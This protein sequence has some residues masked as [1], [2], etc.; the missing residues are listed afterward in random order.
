MW[1]DTHC[2]LDF[3]YENKS[4]DESLFDN[5][6]LDYIICPSAN[7]KSFGIL[8][9]LNQ[10]NKSIV[11]AFGYHPLY[12][13]DLPDNPIQYLENE[14][15]N[16]QPIAVGEI[17]L[18][19]YLRNEEKEKQKII[20]QQQLELASKYKLPVILHVRSAID[21]VLKI[22][23]DFPDIKGI[24]HAFNGSFQQAQQ[25]I[26]MGFK[27]G[28]GGA[29]T[30][31]RAKKINRLALELR[32][33][34]IVLETDAPDMK[35]AWVNATS[36]NHPNEIRGIAEYFAQLRNI[37][38]NDLSGQLKNNIADIFPDLGDAS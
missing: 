29:M 16:S 33:D 19:F 18:D 7:H 31:S 3:I 20:F 23:K 28:F 11:Y 34:S 13:N 27:L 30:Y 14:I 12:L 9:K 1:I 6:L 37:S 5:S 17:G 26:N 36:Q 35:P 38:V 4:K 24:A 8:K 21:D 25:F 2:H 22:L 10:K 15:L 32:I